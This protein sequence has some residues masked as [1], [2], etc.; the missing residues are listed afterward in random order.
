MAENTKDKILRAAKEL[1]GELGYSETTFKR[2]SQRSGVTMGLI[3]HHFGSKDKLFIEATMSVLQEVRTRVIRKVDEASDGISAVRSF[4][5][6]YLSCSVDPQLCFKI[7]VRCSPYSDVRT[8]VSI[9]SVVKGFEGLMHI[10]ARCLIKGM[11]DGT[12]IELNSIKSADI[13]FAAIVGSVRTQLLSPFSFDD[14]Y[15]DATRFI[16]RSVAARPVASPEPV[17]QETRS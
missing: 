6:E 7:L 15:Q 11:N 2:I 4:I 13:I 5:E 12:V 8:D 16:L 1:F 14:F 3:T 17:K 9:D 10:L